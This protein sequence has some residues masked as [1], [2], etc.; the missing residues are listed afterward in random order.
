[1][2]PRTDKSYIYEEFV[3]VDN[4]ARPRL[5]SRYRRVLLQSSRGYQSIYCGAGFLPR[6]DEEVTGS[7]WSR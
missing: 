4:G 3:D 7:R 1:M 5:M 6:G 2:H